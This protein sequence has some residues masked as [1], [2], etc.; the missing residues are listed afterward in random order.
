MSKTSD[1]GSE[2]MEKV[3]VRIVGFEL[4][5]PVLVAFETLPKIEII[6]A[7]DTRR[8][9]VFAALDHGANY[10]GSLNEEF[11]V[12]RDNGDAAE[13]TILWVTLNASQEEDSVQRLKP[14]C[15]LA[16]NW[17]TDDIEYRAASALEDFDPLE[18]EGM[19]LLWAYA[20]YATSAWGKDF[21]VEA[22]VK[23][24]LLDKRLADLVLHGG[25]TGRPLDLMQL[26]QKR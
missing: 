1:G 12:C 10:H 14:F 7:P 21:I 8:L 13:W 17:Q 23:G 20:F 11:F 26:S 25:A 9:K 18:L 2:R 22:K 15:M 16:S 3:D 6:C 24:G 5:V 19:I 4:S